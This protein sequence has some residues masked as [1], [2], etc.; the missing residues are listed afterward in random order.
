MSPPSRDEIPSHLEEDVRL[1][2]IRVT[3]AFEAIT[4]INKELAVLAEANKHRDEKLNS[5]LGLGRTV[6]ITVITLAVG[7]GFA[8]FAAG[9]LHVTP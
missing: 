4:L 8:W 1:L 3:N 2:S 7:A 6:L 9:G 5:I